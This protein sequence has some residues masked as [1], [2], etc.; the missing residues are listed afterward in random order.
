MSAE[1]FHPSRNNPELQAVVS[2]PEGLDVQ[3]WHEL[4]DELNNSELVG[5]KTELQTDVYY[6]ANGNTLELHDARAHHDGR[7]D[8]VFIVRGEFQAIELASKE[9]GT[10]IPCLVINGKYIGMRP[11]HDGLGP[12]KT[13]EKVGLF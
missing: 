8:S 2:A 9:D 7:D 11:T 1:V 5:K 12:P 13:L 3:E 4:I 10:I 6:T